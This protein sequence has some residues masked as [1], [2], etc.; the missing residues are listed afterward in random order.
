MAE[1]NENLPA[2]ATYLLGPIT[3]LYFIATEKKD[4]FIRFHAWQSTITFGVLFVFHVL[5]S[6]FFVF[7]ILFQFQFFKLI[8][9]G[10]GCSLGISDV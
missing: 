8:Q 6:S 9:S 7:G 5:L 10:G 1:N 2:A 4:N 3:G